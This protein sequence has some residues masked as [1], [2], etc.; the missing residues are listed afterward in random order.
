MTAQ[1]IIHCLEKR[2]AIANRAASLERNSGFANQKIAAGLEH[3]NA[4]R[5]QERQRPIVLLKG[6]PLELFMC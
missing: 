6:P 2:N 4:V 3:H 5:R 1:F